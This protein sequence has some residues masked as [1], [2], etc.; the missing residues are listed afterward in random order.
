MNLRPCTRKKW[1][2]RVLPY[3][4]TQQLGLRKSRLKWD[5]IWETTMMKEIK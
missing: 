5:G 1:L 2:R 3:N 4:P